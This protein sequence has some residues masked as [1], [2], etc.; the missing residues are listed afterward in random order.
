MR[1]PNKVKRITQFFEKKNKNAST[2]TKKGKGKTKQV[3]IRDIREDEELSSSSSWSN[4]EDSPK[5]QRE[6]RDRRP[7]TSTATPSTATPTTAG[8]S[9]ALA[10]AAAAGGL[11]ESAAGGSTATPPPPLRGPFG[12]AD[13]KKR[14]RP[15]DDISPSAPDPKMANVAGIIEEELNGIQKILAEG[16]AGHLYESI[17]NKII[18]CFNKAMLAYHR[19]ILKEVDEK[20]TMRR[21]ERR[22]ERAIII[23]NADKLVTPKE[24]TIYYSLAERVTEAL[25]TLC[26]SMVSVVEAFPLGRRTEDRP[27]TSICVVLGSSRMKSVVYRTVAAHIRQRT[28]IGNAIRDIGLRDMFPK[29]YLPEVQ[30]L[31]ST[32]KQLKAAGKISGFKVNAVG[33]GA[34][35]VLYVRRGGGSGERPGPW[36]VYVEQNT[37][38]QNPEDM[39]EE[40]L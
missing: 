30:K 37:N 25:H 34:I 35:P 11:Q 8:T 40:T 9:V 2:M 10:T 21:E 16:G 28:A 12:N 38:E 39:E 1:T 24:E 19:E 5:E 33:A 14:R 7:A 31:A 15:D 29:R 13:G 18:D 4:A 6:K 17:K 27:V 26:R 23:H 3:H 20:L 22:C 32:G 36:R